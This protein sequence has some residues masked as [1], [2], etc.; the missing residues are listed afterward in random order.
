MLER[1]GDLG[2]DVADSGLLLTPVSPTIRA[3]ESLGGTVG[4]Y[5]EPGNYRFVIDYVYTDSADADSLTVVSNEFWIHEP[6]DSAGG[7]ETG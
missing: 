4:R 5:P 2:W 3:G 6:T 7:T 1:I